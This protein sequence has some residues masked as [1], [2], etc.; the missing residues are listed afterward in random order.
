MA[1]VPALGCTMGFWRAH[2]RTSQERDG[3]PGHPPTY[4]RG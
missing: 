3:P 1:G 2:V 4:V